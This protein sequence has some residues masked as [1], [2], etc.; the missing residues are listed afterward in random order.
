[1]PGRGHPQRLRC[2]LPIIA[3]QAEASRMPGAKPGEVSMKEEDALS[4]E[5][6]TQRGKEMWLPHHGEVK[7]RKRLQ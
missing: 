3:H 7:F 1:M 2:L 4:K 6:S 5:K